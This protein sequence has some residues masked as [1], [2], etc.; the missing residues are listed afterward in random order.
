MGPT[1]TIAFT[2]ACTYT[3][4]DTDYFMLQPL[5]ILDKDSAAAVATTHKRGVSAAESMAALLGRSY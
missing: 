2:A 4:G 1:H 3:A 5:S